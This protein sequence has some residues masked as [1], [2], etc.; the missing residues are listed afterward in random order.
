MF[1]IGFVKI[2]NEVQVP[3]TQK[4]SRKASFYLDTNDLNLQENETIKHI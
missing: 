4:S 3:R 2:E 1:W